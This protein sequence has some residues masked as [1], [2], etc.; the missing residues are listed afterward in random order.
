MSRKHCK[1][2]GK[3]YR[4]KASNGRKASCMKKSRKS[5]GK[6]SSRM[7]RK[8]CKSLGKL[9]RK[10]ASNGRKASCMKK[11]GRKSAKRSGRKSKKCPKGQVGS[12]RKLA[13][14]RMGKKVCVPKPFGAAKST[15]TAPAYA[16]PAAPATPAELKAS[17]EDMYDFNLTALG[18]RIKN[19]S[20]RKSRRHSRRH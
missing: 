20:G 5:R 18:Y 16:A 15:Y 2:L 11:S 13:N 14:G 9:Y 6:K 12:F 8:H 4:K 17:G 1:S 19:R 7:S 3:L 10:K